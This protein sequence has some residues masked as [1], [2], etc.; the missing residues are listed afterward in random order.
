MINPQLIN[1]PTQNPQL[2]NLTVE[3]PQLINPQLI[4]PQLINPQLINFG[5]ENPQLIN[6]Q[7][8]NP[9]LINDAFANPQL[10]NPQLINP[11]LINP[12]LINS[13]VSDGS[14]TTTDANWVDFTYAI[15]N[16]GN[17]KTAF[18]ADMTLA[19]EGLENTDSQ[20][21]AW[22]IYASP[23]AD[24]CQYVGQA[25]VQV[26][27]QVNAPDNEL[28]VATIFQ[29][30]AGEVS[31]IAAPGQI[32]YFTR[33]VFGDLQDLQTLQVS[34]FTAASQAAN[35][36]DLEAGEYFCQAVLETNRER[37]LLDTL[38]PT[39][40]LANNTLLP[41]ISAD[42]PGGAC[43]D[44]VGS[45]TVTADDSGE[46]IIPICVSEVTGSPICVDGGGTTPTEGL[47][48]P[49]T[50]PDAPLG[51]ICSASDSNGNESS[52]RLLVNVFDTG[53][54]ELGAPLVPGPLVVTASASLPP[55]NPFTAVVNYPAIDAVD[56]PVVDE[57][58]EV[59]C[60]PESGSEFPI[61]NNTVSC[62]AR[63]DG[64][65]GNS[66][67]ALTF[68]ESEP[69]EFMV[70]VVDV[71]PPVGEAPTFT[72]DDLQANATGGRSNFVYP[73]PTFTDNDTRDTSDVTVDC[74]PAPGLFLPLSPPTS[75][76]CTGTDA[77]N[78]SSIVS[79]EVAAVDTLGPI[80]TPPSAQPVA[81]AIGGD[82]LARPD[83]ESFVTVADQFDVDP[84][85]VATCETSGG[86]RTGDA[87]PIGTYRVSCTA[88]DASG[89]VSEEPA[90]YDLVVQFGSAFGIVVDKNNVKSGSS[91]PTRFGWQGADGR[92]V[93][94]SGADPVVTARDCATQS[95]V[96]LNPGEFP[97]NSDLRYDASQKV[98]KFNWQI[99]DMSGNPIPADTY[100]LR[101]ESRTTGQTA[102]DSGFTTVK[103]RK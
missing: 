79:F 81:V 39:F 94:S 33:R 97:G 92:L 84:D 25:D 1:D 59:I 63:D 93:D 96:V 55:E 53:T 68:N 49:L 76:T 44:L 42:R 45:G 100:C 10:I 36:N 101:A 14:T 47:V 51:I 69:V 102:P 64:P 35:C 67:P 57:D 20:F 43:V 6:P 83:L 12:Q 41:A 40:N 66:P 54:P 2:I 16:T 17:V 22:T 70:N 85:P 50:E 82:G 5:Y 26:L 13:S 78:N 80:V 58:V 52:V 24:A 62:T 103:V 18:N 87:L 9:Q 21:I 90:V 27:S 7:L 74:T 3:N 71:T 89:N 30:F 34:A 15:Q 73:L 56:N 23:T 98:W 86:A 48:I 11:Q 88:T 61:G 29:P 60:F 28:D 99:V 65:N 77:S 4:N 8:I 95:N 37:I 31:A 46:P 72:E 38:P 32:L 75:I 19:G 91:I